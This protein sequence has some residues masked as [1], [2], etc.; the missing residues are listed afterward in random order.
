MDLNSERKIQMRSVI[1]SHLMHTAAKT[2]ADNQ[3]GIRNDMVV[4]VYLK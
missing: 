1:L 4:K 2:K 3:Y